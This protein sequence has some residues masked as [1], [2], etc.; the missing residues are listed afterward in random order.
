MIYTQSLVLLIA[1]SSFATGFDV[2]VICYLVLLLLLLSGDVE[3]NP[4]PM[5]D[6]QPS[7]ILFA[8]YLQTLHDWKPFALCLPGGIG[9]TQL[10]VD[11]IKTK[12]SSYLRMEALHKR[13]LQVNPTAS[14]RDVINAL[15]QC[16]ENELARTIEVKVKNST[17]K[18]L[19][20]KM[21]V[22]TGVIAVDHIHITEISKAT[23]LTVK[24]RND[25][26]NDA[27][28]GKLLNTNTSNN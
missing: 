28:T 23:N 13:W 1:T 18:C 25:S 21:E 26:N 5:I 8:K 10:D 14:W 9:I 6:D 4:G 20:D 3:L 22:N 11:I 2:N 27:K 24:G 19:D 15:K 16:K 7:C 17:G 12:G